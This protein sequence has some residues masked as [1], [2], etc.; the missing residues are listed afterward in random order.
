VSSDLDVRQGLDVRSFEDSLLPILSLNGELLRLRE[1]ANQRQSDWS[2]AEESMVSHIQV[3]M[4]TT[5]VAFTS[6]AAG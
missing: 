2:E 4:I 5:S 3:R 1:N 6:A